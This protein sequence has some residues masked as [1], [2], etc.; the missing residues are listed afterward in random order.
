MEPNPLNLGKKLSFG[1]SR[2]EDNKVLI[3]FKFDLIDSNEYD[4]IFIQR[5]QDG[6]QFYSVGMCKVTNWPPSGYIDEGSVCFERLY[7]RLLLERQ[8]GTDEFINSKQII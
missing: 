1:L 6:D 5:S 8:S 3:T 2:R 4:V 7:Y